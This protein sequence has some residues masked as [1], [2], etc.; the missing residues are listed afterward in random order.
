MKYA[1]LLALL[2]SSTVSASTLSD[3]KAALGAMQG[4]GTL[5]GTY[6]ARQSKTEEESG[7]PETTTVSAKVEDTSGELRIGWDRGLLQRAMEQ[8]Q[9]TPKPDTELSMAINQ[10][11]ANRIAGAVNYAPRLLNIIATGQVKSERSEAW[12]GKP[13]RVLEVAYTPPIDGNSSLKVK[14]NSHTAKLWLGADG[15]PLAASFSHSVRASFMVFISY[16]EK[17]TENYVFAQVANRL[18]A[19]KRE[20]QGMRKGAGQD[21]TFRNVYTF[22][23]Q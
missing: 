8:S 23:P 16:E 4:Q 5:R 18:V 10:N 21:A 22:T 6:E 12:Q 13:A 3:L 9:R 11:S 2:V 17:S 1:A 14:E 20:E 7:K 19:L 15:V